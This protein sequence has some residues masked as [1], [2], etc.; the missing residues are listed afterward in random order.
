MRVCL[1]KKVNSIISEM[2]DTH[3]LHLHFK[4]FQNKTIEISPIVLTYCTRKT[5]E[6]HNCFYKTSF[7]ALPAPQINSMYIVM[8]CL[9]RRRKA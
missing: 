9:C 3:T 7:C 8:T 4:Y 1:V 5:F 2:K 6:L